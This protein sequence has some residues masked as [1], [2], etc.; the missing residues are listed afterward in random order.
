MHMHKHLVKLW[1][2]VKIQL[3]IAHVSEAKLASLFPV[4]DRGTF[5]TASIARERLLARNS[6]FRHL[7]SPSMPQIIA[8]P[9]PFVHGALPENSS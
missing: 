2:S 7:G 4:L 5:A 1:S 3:A 9:G 8:K 6:A